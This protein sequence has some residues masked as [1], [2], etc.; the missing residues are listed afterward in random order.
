MQAAPDVA[1]I[2]TKPLARGIQAIK[3]NYQW[4][5]SL[6]QPLEHAR[7]DECVHRGLYEWF[8][9]HDGHSKSAYLRMRSKQVYRLVHHGVIDRRIDD[10]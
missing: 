10:C 2:N 8:H 9:G 1:G 7:L 6:D 3:H 4:P 5:I